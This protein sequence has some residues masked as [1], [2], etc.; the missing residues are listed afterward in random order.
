MGIYGFNADLM[1]TPPT[2]MGILL[3]YIIGIDNQLKILYWGVS[4]H[5]D[6]NH[7]YMAIQILKG[8]EDDAVDDIPG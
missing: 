6:K 7:Q 3:G 8:E 1:E 4:Q 5:G 2:D